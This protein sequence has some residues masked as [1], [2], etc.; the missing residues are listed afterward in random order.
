MYKA[1][2]FSRE[3]IWEAKID[4]VNREQNEIDFI[5]FVYKMVHDKEFLEPLFPVD[6]KLEDGIKNAAILIKYTKMLLENY[7]N[8]LMEELTKA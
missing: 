8:A 5:S 6:D 4:K 3:N 7:H 2:M 1:L